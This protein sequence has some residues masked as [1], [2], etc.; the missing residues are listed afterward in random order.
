MQPR[1]IT[2]GLPVSMLLGVRVHHATLPQAVEAVRGLLQAGGVH[3]I[4]TV[5]GT[6]LVRA[7]QEER[8]RRVLNEAA[9]AVSD[10][11]GVLL[12]ARLLG[13]P[14]FTR[15]PG[16][17]LVEALCAMA[18]AD[19]YRVF[20]LG[21]APGVAEAAAQA[22]RRQHPGLAVAGVLH[23]Y[24]SDDAAVV[25]QVRRASPHLLFVAMGFPRQEF[26]IAEHRDHLGVPV[27]MGVGGTFDVL[28]GRVSRAPRWVQHLALEWV[29]RLMQEPRR[30]RTAAGL[31][32]LIW[33]ALRER[34]KE[35][36]SAEGRRGY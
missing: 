28:S 20:L 1:V 31:P 30:W 24:M 3:Q 10:G 25:E 11:A 29:Y 4:I 2:V 26:W 21:A 16:V 33:L 19:G 18:A 27:N 8:V 17:E 23:G 14:A 32:R 6:M 13:R 36:V 9:L 5:N 35:R 34:A 15:V 22:L 12:T 7:A